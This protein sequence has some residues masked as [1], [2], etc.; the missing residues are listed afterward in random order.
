MVAPGTV[1]VVGTVSVTTVVTVSVITGFV[2]GGSTQWLARICAPVNPP[3]KIMFMFRPGYTLATPSR[4]TTNDGMMLR[5]WADPAWEVPLRMLSAFAVCRFHTVVWPGGPWQIVIP[6]PDC[7]E[8][9]GTNA[10]PT[11]N[12]PTHIKA[13]APK[14][15]RTSGSL[16][17]TP[18]SASHVRATSFEAAAKRVPR[19]LFPWHPPGFGLTSGSME[20]AGIE[21]AQDSHRRSRRLRGDGRRVGWTHPPPM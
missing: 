9:A 1:T 16:Q 3:L 8:P 21:P 11:P 20:A 5:K 13:T 6:P 7:V 18:T 14:K 2:T 15:R 12:A 4:I 10:A 19:E 17:R